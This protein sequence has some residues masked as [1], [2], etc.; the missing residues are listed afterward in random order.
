MSGKHA[1]DS[2]VC[3]PIQATQHHAES[4]IPHQP[5]FIMKQELHDDAHLQ[6][7]AGRAFF[8]FRFQGATECRSK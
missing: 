4:F 2:T 1:A 7:L 3:E 5:A 6:K 8:Y